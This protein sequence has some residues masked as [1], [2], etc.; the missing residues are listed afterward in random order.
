MAAVVMLYQEKIPAES[1]GLLK[2]MSLYSDLPKLSQGEST[3]LLETRELSKDET[4]LIEKVLDAIVSL[5]K[6]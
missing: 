1:A 4:V 3:E 6:S 2:G 5:K